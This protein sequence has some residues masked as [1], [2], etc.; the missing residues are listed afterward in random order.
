MKNVLVVILIL[1]A[2]GLGLF[3]GVRWC[4]PRLSAQALNDRYVEL[5]DDVAFSYGPLRFFRSG[6]DDKVESL[7]HGRLGSS[8]ESFDT[9][10][11]EH[12]AIRGKNP[13]MVQNA[14]QLYQETM[15]TNVEQDGGEDR[16]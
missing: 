3:A 14:R 9:F 1:I 4:E 7:L 2:F 8:L 13:K 15:D 10:I 11:D 12:P 5:L 16:R 6:E